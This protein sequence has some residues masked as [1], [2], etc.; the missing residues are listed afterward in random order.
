VLLSAD[1]MKT[2][3]VGIADRYNASV[4]EW[5]MI[6]A[7]GVLVIAPVAAVFVFIKSFLAL[8]WG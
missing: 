1:A 8:G 4:V 2:L 6:V 7:A 3:R 5:G